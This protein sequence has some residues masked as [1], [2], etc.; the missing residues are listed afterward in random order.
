M[1]FKSQISNLKFLWWW[2]RQVL[3]D[4]A[5]ENYLRCADRA[6]AGPL[7]C[8]RSSGTDTHIRPCPRIMSREEF[9]LDSLHRRYSTISRC[10]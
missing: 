6:T 3:G 4:A 9:F 2:L 1:S 5:Y 7:R 10:C 8:V